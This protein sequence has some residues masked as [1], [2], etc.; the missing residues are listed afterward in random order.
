MKII[1]KF[2]HNETVI[3]GGLGAEK[4]Q[5]IVAAEFIPSKAIANWL[6]RLIPPL[7]HFK[8]LSCIFKD[9][10]LTFVFFPNWHFIFG[11]TTFLLPSFYSSSI[12]FSLFHAPQPS[13]SLLPVLM[14]VFWSSA[15]EELLLYWGC[16]QPRHW[17]GRA[18]R[19][20][21]WGC[22]RGLRECASVDLK[23]AQGYEAGCMTKS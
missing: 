7:M 22:S 9:T 14:C 1:I 5:A 21:C 16:E 3:G 23:S 17:L 15:I 13:T 2:F 18:W 12:F 11:S 20:C 4:A 8:A 6:V 10:V 19:R